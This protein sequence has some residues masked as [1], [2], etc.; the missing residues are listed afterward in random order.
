MMLIYI[1][2]TKMLSALQSVIIKA[3]LYHF[4]V[5]AVSIQL[6]VTSDHS[7]IAV[8]FLMSRTSVALNNV[9]STHSAFKWS[10]LLCWGVMLRDPNCSGAALWLFS[11]VFC[12]SSVIL[13]FSFLAS[14][15]SLLCDW[16]WRAAHTSVWEEDAQ[17]G[18]YLPDRSEVS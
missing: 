7:F 15:A 10:V 16:C 18:L 14:A 13:F 9:S 3:L 2:H 6:T 17:M 12:R 1:T 11:A 4:F 8:K 5:K